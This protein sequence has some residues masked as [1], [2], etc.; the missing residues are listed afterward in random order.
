M[1]HTMRALLLLAVVVALPSFAAPRKAA[2][3]GDA[4]E[5]DIAD[6]LTHP[7]VSSAM[8][9]VAGPARACY[10]RVLAH[11]PGL[12]GSL[13]LLFTVSPEGKVAAL[14]VTDST[15]GNGDIE[16]CLVEVVKT[17]QFPRQGSSLRVVYPWV[18]RPLDVTAASDQ[19]LLRAMGWAV[20]PAPLEIR[21]QAIEDLGLLGDSRALNLLAQLSVD[22]NPIIASAAVR[23]LSSMRHPRAEEILGNIVRHPTLPE[24]LKLQALTMLPFQNTWSAF[25][26]VATMAR[27]GGGSWRLQGEA[28]KMLGWLPREEPQP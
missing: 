2:P 28:K 7:G 23:A 1:T 9:A 13:K 22:P 4:K 8:A 20:E 15:L 12:A 16:R 27:T 5:E 19:A 18:F 17:V 6:G 25:H 26:S 3:L 10:A 11:T 24:S 14:E 21:A